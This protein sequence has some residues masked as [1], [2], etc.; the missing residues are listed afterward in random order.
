ML[1]LDPLLAQIPVDLAPIFF[2]LTVFPWFWDCASTRPP[3]PPG[4]PPPPN[5]LVPA[6]PPYSPLPSITFPEWGNL[7][8]V[9]TCEGLPLAVGI[10]DYWWMYLFP[11]LAIV[12][13]GFAL[14]L[15]CDGI[16]KRM[17]R[18]PK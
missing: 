16:D 4:A 18:R 11:L 10:P 14:A 1:A 13:L 3:P 15:V 8:A 12:G 6:L 2:V 9:G 7:L 5:Y 17:S